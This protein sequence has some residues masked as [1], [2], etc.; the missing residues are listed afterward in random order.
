MIT[1]VDLEDVIVVE[2]N[3]MAG[4]WAIYKPLGHLSHKRVG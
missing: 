4:T 3:L 1:L 2:K